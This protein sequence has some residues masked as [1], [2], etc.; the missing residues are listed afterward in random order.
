MRISDVSR[1]AR[2]RAVR[3]SSVV[4][5]ALL[6]A[7]S[8][9]RHFSPPP[10]DL[11]I[12]HARLLDIERETIQEVT[13]VVVGDRISAV[14][15][16]GTQPRVKALRQIDAGN[17]LVMPGLIDSHVHLLFLEAV[18]S[19]TDDRVVEEFIRDGLPEKLHAFL[20]HGVTS[21][22]TTGDYY[23]VI[24]SV[25]RAI[26]TGEMLGPRVFVVGPVFTAPG[27]HPAGTLC[28][29]DWCRDHAT[30]QIQS[31]DVARAHV[32]RL[33][34]EGVDG[35]KV[36]HGRMGPSLEILTAIVDEAHQHLLRVT[37]HT[38]TDDEALTALRAGA[39][40]LEHGVVEGR[41]SDLTLAQL[42]KRGASYT[43]TLTIW[44]HEPLHLELPMANLRRASEAGVRIVLG[45]DQHDAPW[46]VSTPGSWTIDELEWMVE[47]GLTR[48][49]VLL[50]ATQHAARHLGVLDDLG[51]IESGKLADLILLDGNPLE[52]L[53]VLR[54]PLMVIAAGKV[55][56]EGP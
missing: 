10:A 28:R 47:A 54:R 50:A 52:D 24:L 7:V 53:S 44:P 45:S 31:A 23:P 56:I 46:T 20:A 2:L 35:I 1:T 16:A 48:R 55:V 13:I 37:V 49:E 43:P 22:K 25:R 8:A 15:A 33:S 41:I 38:W 40:G 18:A 39:D 27:G 26:T 12:K 34:A 5:V 6:L 29:S 14:Y 30:I 42:R 9:C 51:T 17:A 21:V 36:V 19:K 4:L 32:R 3:Y 11:V